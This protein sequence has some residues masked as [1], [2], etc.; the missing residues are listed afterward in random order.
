M[1]QES[2]KKQL[3]QHWLCDIAVLDSIVNDAGVLPGDTVLEVG[4]G[5]GTLT[6][7]LLKKG[8]SVIAVEFDQ[9][10][11]PKLK[12]NLAKQLGEDVCQGLTVIEQDILKFDFNS[13]TKNYKLV[14]NIPY[15]LT[16]HLLRILSEND[17]PP[18]AAAILVQKEVAERVCAKPGDM[19]ILSVAVQTYFN[20]SLGSVV[21]AE[22]FTPPP[23]VDSQVLILKRRPEALINIEESKHFFSI[24]KAGF[25]EKR[26]KLRSSLSG[27]LHI[28]KEQA[29]LLLQKA[30]IDPNLRA[31]SLTLE[32]WLI[33][34]KT[35]K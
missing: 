24:V 28:S 30:N 25:S 19:S 6:A 2:P 9:D 32:E 34:A 21:G 18:I 1:A 29:D 7:R 23:K 17:N 31:Q 4:P 14:A 11:A 10:L 12:C 15:Y 26:K 35:I 13:L 16:S 27:G 22:L 33:L 3:G 20:V 5:L 8:A